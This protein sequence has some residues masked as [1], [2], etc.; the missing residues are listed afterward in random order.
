MNQYFFATH[1]HLGPFLWINVSYSPFWRT[2]AGLWRSQTPFETSLNIKHHQAVFTQGAVTLPFQVD[3]LGI[4][5]ADAGC[6]SVLFQVNGITFVEKCCCP[7]GFVKFHHKHSPFTI[8][9]AG[10]LE[11]AAP[12]LI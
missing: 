6:H 2:S 3:V 8:R 10:Q 4:A 7:G 9:K 1:P 11:D 5:V 12:L